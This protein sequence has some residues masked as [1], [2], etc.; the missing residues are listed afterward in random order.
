MSRTLLT[1]SPLLARRAGVVCASVLL[2]GGLAAVPAGAA[3]TASVSGTAF[4]DLDRDGVPD[5][6]E[7]RLAGHRVELTSTTGQFWGVT[8]DEAGRYA[9][10]GLA[11]GLYRVDVGSTTYAGL[12]DDWVPTTGTGLRPYRN[13]Q[14][15][16]AA[17]VDLGW[18]RI[19]RSTDPEAPISTFTGP[20]GLR[21]ESF[22]DVVPARELHDVL[23]A[24]TL[25]GEAASTVV[26]FD[27]SGSSS[28][29]SA[30]G[31]DGS[32]YSGFAA[33]SWV[34][35]A[36]WRDRGA[37]TLVHEHGHAW[38]TYHGAI[39]QQDPSLSAYL[40]A[41]G[42]E[43]DPR[44][45]SGYAWMP[46]EL[47]AED[48]RQLLGPAVAAGGE[49]MNRELPR[50]ADV[51]G[52]REFLSTTFQQPVATSAPTTAPAPLVVDQLATSTGKRGTTVSFRASEAADADVRV[53][54]GA[55]RLVRAVHTGPV[56]AGTTSVL[57]D[58]KDAAGRRVRL[59]G[60]S[61]VVTLTDGARTASASARL[62]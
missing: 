20:S 34:T 44:V 19:V 5:A 54:D 31:Q 33:R 49:Q 56:P 10:P 48:Y 52:L 30:Y 41:R 51:P 23:A 29:S 18:R 2:L 61:V 26:V 43:G 46:G 32:T 7:P 11:E 36:S 1:R 17:V 40:R 6:G 59:T 3:G 15:A 16:G 9:F 37:E 53:V 58:G 14:V 57:W 38:G 47:L 50:A 35:Y 4:E 27:L 25:T 24:G 42:L 22:D 62:G 13:V 55:G 28:T 8:T 60:L 39:T 21:V 12:R 45:G